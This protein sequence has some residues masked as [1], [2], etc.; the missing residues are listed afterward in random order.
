MITGYYRGGLGNQL[1]QVMSGY[2][3]ALDNDD[4]YFINCNLDLGRGQGKG[5]SE[6]VDNLF[7]NIPRTEFCPPNSHQEITMNK[8]SKIPYTK[9]LVL[10]GY[11]QS[12]K[13]FINYKERIS[14]ILNINTE[15]HTNKTCVIHVRLGDYLTEGGYA[16]GTPFYFKS[17]IDF[18]RKRN[19]EIIFKLVSDNPVLAKTYL[20]NEIEYEDLGGNEID[21]LT[22][23]SQADCV[24]MTNS[25]FGWWGSYLGKE[26]IT[27]VANPWNLN[28]GDYSDTYREDMIKL[29][30]AE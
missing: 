2:A 19:S 9:D 4:E 6:Y 18:I 21:H 28:P 13:Y 17:A 22:A 23:M 5:I 15:S 1:F 16:V 3:L 8:Y 12:D 20:P 11:Y 10:N 14:E 7:K 27:I 24:I 30:I 26:K 29:P 25:T